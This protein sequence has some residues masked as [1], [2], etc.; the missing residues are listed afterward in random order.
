MI[1]ILK[2]VI[3][4]LLLVANILFCISLLT[5]LAVVKLVLPFKPVR[6]TM[7]FL[8]SKVAE[9]WV[10]ANSAWI[11]WAQP[12]PWVVTGMGQFDPKGWYL[13]SCNHQSWVDILVLQRIFN[14]R[15][16]M[17]KFFLKQQLIYVPIMGFAWWALDFPFMNRQGGKNAAKDLETARQSCEK[18]KLIPT[19]V[20]SFAEGTRFEVRKHE[21]QQSP[22]QHLLKPKVGALAMAL[23]T[24]GPLFTAMLDVTIVYPQAVPTFWDLLC[25]R[26]TQ[27]KVHVRSVPIPAEFTQAQASLASDYRPRLQAWMNELWAAKDAQIDV[28]LKPSDQKSCCSNH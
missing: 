20:I 11:K 28:L 4:S 16:P 12:T 8:L 24:M 14:Q 19:S 3:S 5:P 17:L 26:V 21:T 2:G 10:G 22:Y 1:Q 6:R 15:I 23:D 9:L 25:G 27:V 13:V 18:F 7:D